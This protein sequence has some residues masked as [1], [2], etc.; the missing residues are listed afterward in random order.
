MKYSISVP[1]IFP[2]GTTFFHTLS[3]ENFVYFPDGTCARLTD[4]GGLMGCMS[5]VRR[6]A[7]ISEE[8]F[9]H[10]VQIY[11]DAAARAAS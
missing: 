4:E 8:A 3:G 2:I 10:T 11:S 5:V 7:A 9:R 6:G 1:S